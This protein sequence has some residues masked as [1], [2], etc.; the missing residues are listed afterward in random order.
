[1]QELANRCYEGDVRHDGPWFD[2]E[3]FAELIIKSCTEIMRVDAE[4]LHDTGSH[5]EAHCIRVLANGIERS[6]GIK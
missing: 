2:K 5:N 1:M 4:C 6:F 3:K